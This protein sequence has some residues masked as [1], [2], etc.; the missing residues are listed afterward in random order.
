VWNFS[1]E[2]FLTSPNEASVS[3][4]RVNRF[5]CCL[6]RGDDIKPV[7]VK[8]GVHY[9]KCL[10]CGLV[11]QHPYP[12][13]EEIN[14]YYE[15]Y[16][17]L[18]SSQSEYLSD[19]GQCVFRRDKTLTFMDLG[20]PKDCFKD[21]RVLDV[22]CATGDFV[23]M[24]S[25]VG[26]KTVLGIDLS[27]E[28]ISEA[29]ARGLPCQLASYTDISEKFDVI[30]MFHVIEHIIQPQD[31]IEHSFKL[32]SPGGMLLVET[33]VIGLI[34]EAFGADW[35]YFMPTEHLNL[36][37]ADCLIRLCNLHGFSLTA[38]V[39]FGSGNDSE[40]I[41]PPNKRAMDAIAKKCGFGDT[42]AIWLSKPGTGGESAFAK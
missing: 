35:R 41:S 21:K 38:Q 28:C 20:L 10:Q 36:F 22:G 3:K 26:A 16:K 7:C 11:R 15:N 9:V 13:T 12:S 5:E 14:K 39:R 4:Q 27:A 1:I 17:S 32:L 37:T 23:E 19:N 29:Q 30:T 42:L 25:G 18:K 2:R 8:L 24:I 33:P 40:M 6:C 31:F 34:S